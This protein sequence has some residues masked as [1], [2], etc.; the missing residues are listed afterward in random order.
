MLSLYCPHPVTILSRSCCCRALIL[1]RLC[2]DCTPTLSCPCHVLILSLSC[3]H[4]V[5][6]LSPF[7]L[8]SHPPLLRDTYPA[9]L[10]AGTPTPSW[11]TGRSTRAK[12][13]SRR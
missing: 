9:P 6:F 11:R 2:T 13:S 4:C 10:L 12:K 7:P 1:S 3:L 8:P 5:P